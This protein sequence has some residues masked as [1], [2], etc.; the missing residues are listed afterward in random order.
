MAL[1]Y[2]EKHLGTIV[3]VPFPTL[4]SQSA[5]QCRDHYLNLI[6]KT[7]SVLILT[8][9]S[10]SRIFFHLCNLSRRCPTHYPEIPHRGVPQ[11]V[12]LYH[13]LVSITPSL[14]LPYIP[15]RL[16]RAFNMLSLSLFTGHASP[17]S[18]TPPSFLDMLG[19]GIF[20]AVLSSTHP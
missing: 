3:I 19:A 10:S 20:S 8:P 13:T 17:C 9:L 11:D 2:N 16:S 6:P 18:T 5:L 15:K 4:P 1:A 12:M 14:F 7:F